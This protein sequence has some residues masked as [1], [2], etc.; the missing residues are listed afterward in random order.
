[1]KTLTKKTHIGHQR[2]QN[3]ESQGKVCYLLQWTEQQYCNYLFEQ[4]CSF[5]EEKYKDF[6]EVLEKRILYSD[7]FRGVFNNAA[8][9]RDREEFIPY[10]EEVT[11]TIMVI[12]PEGCLEWFQ[13]VPLGGDYLIEEW[14]LIHSYKRLI[15]DDQFMSQFRHIVEL[16]KIV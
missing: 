16:N 9:K 3:K 10:A 11:E 8:S 13:T 15:N 12:T 1:M 5:I 14:E 7:L 6:P 2:Q 4:Y